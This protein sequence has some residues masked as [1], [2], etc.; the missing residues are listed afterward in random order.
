MRNPWRFS[1]DRDNG[2]L[3]IADVGQGEWEEIDHLPAADGGDAG[4]GREPRAG[5]AWRAATRSRAATNP[6][7]GGA[8]RPRVRP[9]R[10]AAARW[11]AA[12]CTGAPPSPTSTGAYLYTDYCLPG[13]SALTLGDAGVVDAARTFDLPVQQVQSFGEDA[14]GE[15]YLLLASGEVLRLVEGP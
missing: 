10:R 14:D 1:F 9:R 4:R 11:S 6:P 5:T 15:L 3:W 12:T 8:A 7:D 2:D 13:L